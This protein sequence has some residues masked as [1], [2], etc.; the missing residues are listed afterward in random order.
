MV[1]VLPLLRFE[2]GPYGGEVRIKYFLVQAWGSALFLSGFLLGQFVD[3][4]AYLV[5][6]ALIMKLGAAPLHL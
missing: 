1:R 4:G 2:R 6:F 5:S 3:L